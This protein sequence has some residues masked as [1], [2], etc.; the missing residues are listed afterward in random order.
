MRTGVDMSI[1]KF[2][3]LGIAFSG[4]LIAGNAGAFVGQIAVGLGPMKQDVGELQTSFSADATVETE[5]VNAKTRIFYKP[6]KL[7]DEMNMGDQSMVT[8]HRLD[9]GKMWM[10]LP[11][12]MY[13]EISP[14]QGNQQAP[15]YR[16]IER[17]VIGKETVNGIEAT[18]YK[19][20]YETDDGKFGGFT[21][22]T[23][24]N[25]AVKA[26]IIS[27]TNGEKHRM[28]F[29]VTD[30]RRGPQDDALFELPAGAKNMSMGGFGGMGTSAAPASG[31]FGSPAVAAPDSA[32]GSASASTPANVSAQQDG[33]FAEEIAETAT[34]TAEDT[35]KEETK[36]SVRDEVSK[37]IRGLFGR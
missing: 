11:Q 17:E 26:F 36:N 9:T 28:Q 33:G 10:V 1:R 31:G 15:N 24:D 13:M 2:A 32:S 30:L 25:I 27:E 20:V 8:I 29:E 4:L 37:G 34:Q 35:A 3:I 19:S 23:D 14:D 16:L 7:R 12:N 18:K 22:F 5:E 6:G 21:W